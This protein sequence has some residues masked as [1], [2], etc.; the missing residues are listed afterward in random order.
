MANIF[1]LIEPNLDS[2]H[3]VSVARWVGLL[4]KS[5][6]CGV[7]WFGR[8]E[9]V[10][11]KRKVERHQAKRRL[12]GIELRQAAIALV[13]NKELQV[14]FSAKNLMGRKRLVMEQG[15]TTVINR[16][17]MHCEWGTETAD[18]V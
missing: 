1:F 18:S 8:N 7:L 15:R 4:R 5:L 6:W 16:L 2:W 9:L 12:I 11:S 13:C 3:A 17:Y 14:H 10:P